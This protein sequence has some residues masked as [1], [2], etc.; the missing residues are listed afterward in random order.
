MAPD[1]VGDQASHTMERLLGRI[2]Q[3][4]GFR[5]VAMCTP[6]TDGTA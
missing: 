2:G 6:S 5:S 1:V 4:G 3:L